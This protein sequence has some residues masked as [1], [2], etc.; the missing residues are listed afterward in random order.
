MLRVGVLGVAHV[1]TGSYLANFRAQADLVG[2]WDAEIE[3]EGLKRFPTPEALLEVV[4]AVAISGMNV[5]HEALAL[6][7]AQAK[8]PILCEKP[9]ATTRRAAQNIVRAVRENNVQLMTAFPCRF[10]PAYRKLKAHVQGGAIGEI[11]GICATNRGTC[12]GG[13]FTDRTKSGGGAMIDHV[14]HVA[15]LLKDLLQQEP[16]H[17]QA[18]LGNGVYGQSWED[19]AMVELAYPNGVFA[20]LDSSW[21]RPKTFKTWGDVTMTVVGTAGTMDMDMFGQEALAYSLD[22]PLR[23][24]AYGSDLDARMI[25]EF[26][27][28]V[29]ENR[30]PLVTGED[31]LAALEVALKAYDS[32]TRFPHP[33]SVAS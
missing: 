26:L 13:W 28:A 15:D 8:K 25:A 9:L 18:H 14:V 11:V 10:S 21:S 6:K 19:T 16:N 29:K 2:Y 31:G 24:L 7:A 12:P 32:Q 1:H 4:D 20:T 27:A 23:T 33:E 22:K 17:V 3:L 5:E 30:E